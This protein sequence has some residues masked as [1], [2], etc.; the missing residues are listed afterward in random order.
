MQ[1]SPTIEALEGRWRVLTARLGADGNI[2]DAVLGELLSAYGEPGRHY[3]TLEH[4]AALFALLDAHG[5]EIAD[6]N[7]ME[8][9]IFFHD[10]VYDPARSDN[11]AASAALAGQRLSALSLPVDLIPKV[12]QYVLATRHGAHEPTEGD[13]DLAL[14]LDLDLSILAAEPSAYADYARAIRREYAHVSDEAYRA[15]RRR[16]LAAFLARPRIYRTDHLHQIWDAKARSNIASEI[17]QLR[18]GT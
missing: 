11:E 18:D 3:H 5:G 1:R 9:A 2:A 10:A 16:V 7:A 6:R 8:L 12:E 14:L 13:A 17:A 15:G 4:L